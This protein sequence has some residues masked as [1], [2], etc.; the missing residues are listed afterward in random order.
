M[1]SAPLATRMNM[2]KRAGALA[3]DSSEDLD[4]EWSNPITGE[5]SEAFSRFREYRDL[6]AVRTFTNIARTSNISVSAVAQM[7]LKY[8]WRDRVWAYDYH[9]QR[10]AEVQL[11]RQRKEARETAIKLSMAMQSVAAYGLVELQQKIKS[12]QALDMSVSE[13]VAIAQLGQKLVDQGLGREPDGGTL[14]K[15]TVMKDGEPYDF[16]MKNGEDEPVN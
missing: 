2:I 7:A 5:S 1:A 12:G 4:S 3:H 8:H 6:G 16:S 14:M 9:N 13:L 10:Q 11:A 15:I